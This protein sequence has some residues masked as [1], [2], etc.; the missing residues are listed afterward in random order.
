RRQT[1]FPYP[2]CAPI[3]DR[4]QQRPEPSGPYRDL[5]VEA[6]SRNQEDRNASESGE[7][8]VDTEQNQRGCMSV[9][10]R[11]FE[12]TCDQVRIKRRLPGSRTSVAVERIGESLASRNCAP[13]AAHLEA[14][15]KI[16]INRFEFISV[17]GDDVTESKCEGDQ[18]HPQKRSPRFRPPSR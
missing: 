12:H 8:A 9:N 16:S 10:P 14:E 13:D 15:T 7:Q 17:I 1:R 5:F 6:L 3:H 4:R 11:K 2:A 18:D